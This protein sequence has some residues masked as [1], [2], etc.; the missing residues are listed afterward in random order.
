MLLGEGMRVGVVD[1][2]F[3]MSEG[4]ESRKALSMLMVRG[5]WCFVLALGNKEQEEESGGVRKTY[6]IEANALQSNLSHK[7][8]RVH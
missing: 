2:D 3:I 7:F 5:T 8:C 6:A 4:R 1:R